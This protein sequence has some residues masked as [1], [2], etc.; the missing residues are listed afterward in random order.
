MWMLQARRLWIF[1]FLC[2]D[3]TSYRHFIVVGGFQ[4]QRDSIEREWG[5]A[6]IHSKEYDKEY[7][8]FEW[9]PFLEELL[10]CFAYP[11]TNFWR[12]VR[13]SPF[14]WLAK[15]K[16]IGETGPFGL[17]FSHVLCHFNSTMAAR[18]TNPFGQPLGRFYFPAFIS[19]S[20]LPMHSFH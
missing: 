8:S 17:Q 10:I 9:L 13:S 3:I 19:E 4:H 2:F 12:V 6:E 11:T 7:R 5:L 16:K 20:S 14:L 15:Q 1:S 18:I